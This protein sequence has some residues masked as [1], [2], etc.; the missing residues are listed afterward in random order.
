MRFF[1]FSGLLFFLICHAKA[2]SFV[3]SVTGTVADKDSKETL[4]GATVIL[5]GSNPLIGTI[6]DQNGVFILKNV[7]VGRQTLLV[8]YT[9]YSEIRVPEILV[10]TGKVVNLNIE[11]SQNLKRLNEVQV[12]ASETDKDKSLNA[13][14]VVSARKLNMDDAGR[15]AGGFFDASRMVSSFAGVTAVEGDGVNDIIIR[16]NSSRGLLWRL[17]GIEIPNPNH[18]TDGQ[19]GTGGAVSI[20]SS[21]VLSTSDFFTG[22]FPAEY[23][24]A[25][26][27]IM[28]LNLRTGKTGKREYAFQFGVV[29]TEFCLEGG[30]TPQSKSSYLINYRYSTFGYLSKAGLIDLGN[31][32]L[33]P[34]FQDLSAKFN[35]PTRNAGTFSLFMV[36]GQSNTG[37]QAVEDSAQWLSDPDLNYF[38][39]EDH[40]M[41]VAGLKHI[42]MFPGNKTSVKTVIA[43][44]YQSDEWTEGYLT[45]DYEKFTGYHSVYTYPSLRAS[46]LI[47]S[48]INN[49]NVLRGGITHNVL[50]Y[51]MMHRK[52]NYNTDKYDILVDQKGGSSMTQAFLQHKYRFS[53]NTELNAG[54]HFLSFQLNGNKSLEPRVGIRHKFNEKAALNLGVGL[55]SRVESISTYMALIE[56]PDGQRSA[57]NKN[58]GLGK[59]L[60]SVVGFDYL[61]DKNWRIKTEAYYQHI[62]NVAES[63]DTTSV[64]S[65]INF[66]YGIPDQKLVNTGKGFN[67][68][69][70]LTVERFFNQGYY[71]LFTT[72]LYDSKFRAPNGKWYSTAFDG[73][74]VCNLLSGKDF[75]VGSDKQ[76][77]VGINTKFVVRGGYRISP[78]DKDASVMNQ[79]IVFDQ[80][81][82]NKN[83]LPAFL[84]FD[85]GAYY[86]INKPACSYIVSLDVQNII[87]RKNTLW[88]EYSSAENSIVAVEGM[89]LVPVLNFRIEF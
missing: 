45:P 64:L 19:G 69:L 67:Y 56:Q 12:R 10:T 39:K 46:V 54:L 20:I 62:Y 49:R 81:R 6:T 71:F 28:D 21:K 29:G 83:Q 41:A 66:G 72:S 52:F 5:V 70:E 60:H 86:R 73:G 3:Q 74:Y 1:V 65:S 40:K 17:D 36:A 37:T 8:T 82:Y 22:A 80:S 33:P 48:K 27:G 11:L 51:D 57:M 16:G 13:M 4:V 75:C 42:Y 43:G 26:S 59:A 14:S 61:I 34:V 68:G 76:N 18:F 25:T 9:G 77:V 53:E 32:N 15:Y 55:H 23:G 84:R 7:P 31:N 50:G 35:F 24:N 85:F 79:E 78:F 38:E 2:G 47:N 89:G 87:N 30:F 88:Y 44:T 63:A 58:A